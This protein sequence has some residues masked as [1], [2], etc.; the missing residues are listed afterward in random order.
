MLAGQQGANPYATRA[1]VGAP[2]VLLVLAGGMLL[3]PSPG[4]RCTIVTDG[5]RKVFVHERAHCNGWVHAMFEVADPP[6]GYVH[7]YAGR[8]TVIQCGGR[9]QH[10]APPGTVFVPGCESV[11]EQC[12]KMWAERGIDISSY[13]SMPYYNYVSGCQFFE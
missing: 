12:R 4:N 1:L 10:K 13:A 3:V 5:T 7:D 6:S 8:L 11:M 2:I 9:H